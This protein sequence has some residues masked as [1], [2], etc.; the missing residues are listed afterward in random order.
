MHNNKI[1][2]KH[3]PHIWASDQEKM[4]GEDEEYSWSNL[5]HPL[6]PSLYI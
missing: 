1:Y 3:A 5:I 4:K 2:T 6:S